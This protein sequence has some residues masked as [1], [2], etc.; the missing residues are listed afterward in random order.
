VPLGSKRDMTEAVTAQ[1][2]RFA[3]GF[4]DTIVASAATP[5]SHLAQSNANYIDGDIAAGALTLRR[6]LL[7]PAAAR[8]WSPYRTGVP[9]HYLCSAATPPGPGVHGM[10]GWHAAT[11]VLRR[12]FG[13]NAPSLAPRAL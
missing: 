13:L 10:A 12:E 4:R 7:G 6:L 11:E 1:I 2:E 5:A 8:R 3:P 9:G